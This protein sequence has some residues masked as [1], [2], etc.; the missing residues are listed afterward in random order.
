MCSNDV[1]VKGVLL[2]GS[3][4]FRFPRTPRFTSCKTCKIWYKVSIF[5]AFSPLKSSTRLS[6]FEMRLAWNWPP[7]RSGSHPLGDVD[8]PLPLLS[9][10]ALEL[11]SP[12]IPVGAVWD[13]W[14]SVSLVPVTPVRSVCKEGLAP[15]QAMGHPKRATCASLVI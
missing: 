1:S 5:K 8:V 7:P 15:S 11:H 10:K 6:I 13:D 14:L 2:K 4:S 12:V 9:E 3:L